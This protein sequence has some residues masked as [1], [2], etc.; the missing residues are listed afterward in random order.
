MFTLELPSCLLEIP[1]YAYTLLSQVL[2]RCSLLQADWLELDN[3]EKATLQ[4]DMPDCYTMQ[5]IL[6]GIT[7]R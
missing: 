2:I 4:I 3:N 1:I 7:S 5:P 6:R